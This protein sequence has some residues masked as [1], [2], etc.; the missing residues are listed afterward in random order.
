M[1]YNDQDH[2]RREYLSTL[3]DHLQWHLQNHGTILSKD[4]HPS[5]KN[6]QQ[7]VLQK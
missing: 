2:S 1:I 4:P 3:Q 7:V 6:L 5:M